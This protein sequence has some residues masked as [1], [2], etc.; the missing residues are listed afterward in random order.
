MARRADYSLGAQDFSVNDAARRDQ[1]L[2]NN[3]PTLGLLRTILYPR[4]TAH[5]ARG[6]QA[7][8][9]RSRIGETAIG[10]RR[11]RGPGKPDGV[12]PEAEKK[13]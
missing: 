12:F 6:A 4:E 3:N 9:G 8:P 13:M 10:D 11:R 1:S 2:K 7:W 5:K